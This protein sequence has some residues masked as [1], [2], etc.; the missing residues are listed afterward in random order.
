MANMRRRNVIPLAVVFFG[1]L[2]LGLI[3]GL[4]TYPKLQQAMNYKT[5][6]HQLC[7]VTK[8][9]AAKGCV[10][11]D[12][13]YFP[14]S[15]ACVYKNGK[16]SVLL[17]NVEQSK[18]LT[19][20][21]V[22][23]QHACYHPAE[24]LA[25]ITFDSPPRAEGLILSFTLLLPFGFLIAVGSVMLM[26]KPK[27][28][29]DTMVQRTE[30]MIRTHDMKVKKL[31]EDN[32]K[33]IATLKGKIEREQEKRLQFVTELTQERSERLRQYDDL[34]DDLIKDF[35]RI[36]DKLG[37]NTGGITGNG[38]LPIPSSVSER[39][40]AQNKNEYEGLIAFANQTKRR[41]STAIDAERQ[42]QDELFKKR[43]A[44]RRKKNRL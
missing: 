20:Y 2:G 24:D 31:N 37:L 16:P 18:Y 12:L 21:E 3:A 36:E 26:Y 35:G 39:K 1:L 29:I 5:P 7:T 10:Q 33:E 28:K 40:K 14:Y 17:G 15:S 23:S 11:V 32:L 44:E 22:G 42:R 34:K 19:S 6:A 30:K 9:D 41:Q 43:L 4:H 38:I 27:P 8:R 25:Q 13:M